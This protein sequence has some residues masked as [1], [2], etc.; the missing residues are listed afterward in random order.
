MISL[1]YLTIVAFY[2]YSVNA[3]DF[4]SLQNVFTCSTTHALLNANTSAY[5]DAAR[6]K[7]GIKGVAISIVQQRK[8]AEEEWITDYGLFGTANAV[9]NLVTEDVGCL[10][11]PYSLLNA[12]TSDTSC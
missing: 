10:S 6:Q 3:S 9:G 2:L 7:Y 1:V 4:T 12:Q 11:I 5:I 8:T